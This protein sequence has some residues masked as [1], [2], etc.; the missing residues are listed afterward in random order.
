MTLSRRALLAAALAL[1]AAAPAPAQDRVL[2]MATGDVTGAYFPAG[3]ALCRVV[4]AERRRHGLRCAAVPAAGSIAN[5]QALR[6]GEVELAIVQSDAQDAALR[7]VGPFAAA[8]PFD[9]LRSVLALHPEPL[10]LVA[11]AEAGVAGLTDLPGKRVNLGAPGSGQRLVLDAL[12]DEL[13]WREGAFA[14]AT[15][16]APAE[17]ANALCEG[18]LDAFFYVVGHPAL[19]V[20]EAVAGCG[21]RLL[22]LAGPEVDAAAASAPF[23]FAAEIPADAYLGQDDAVPSFGVGAT[24]V[25]RAD[26]PAEEIETLAGGILDALS[27]LAGFDPTLAGLDPAAARRRGLTAPLHPGAEAAFQARGLLD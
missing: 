15:E 21:A 12:F 23:Y 9:G 20:R 16:L 1:A 17:A 8:G 7:G 4:N 14:E 25:T 11:R 27:A 13:G 10:T 26:L 3:V 24:L 18:R 19:A 5:L 2:A 6:A 22:P